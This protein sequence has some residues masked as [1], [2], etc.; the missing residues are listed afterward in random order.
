MNMHAAH[1]AHAHTYTIT[2]QMCAIMNLAGIS[3]VLFS[4]EKSLEHTHLP[5]RYTP[6]DVSVMNRPHV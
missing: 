5:L 4:I 3:T 1:M 6:Y 2:L